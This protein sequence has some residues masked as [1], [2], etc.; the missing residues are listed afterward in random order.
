MH[1]VE[2][3]LTLLGQASV[4]KSC[5]TYAFDAAINRLPIPVL[6]NFSPYA[7]LFRQPPNYLK[8]RI[9]GCM[10]FRWVRSYTTYKLENQSVSCVFVGY[11]LTQN[12]YLCMDTATGHLYTSRPISRIDFLLCSNSPDT[13]PSNRSK[14]S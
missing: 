12:A 13:N 5:W 7:K 2:T 8:L 11:S 9:F 6:N 10:C 14:P 4:P 1:I 3:G